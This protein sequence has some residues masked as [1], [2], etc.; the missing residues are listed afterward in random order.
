[1]RLLVLLQRNAPPFVIL[2]IPE[3]TAVDNLLHTGVNQ[4]SIGS[5][6]ETGDGGMEVGNVVIS[7]VGNARLLCTAFNLQID[8]Q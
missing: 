2:T 1:M 8:F 7:W 3:L 4:R 6:Y 5:Y